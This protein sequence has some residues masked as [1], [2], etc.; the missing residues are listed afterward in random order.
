M[1]FCKFNFMRITVERDGYLLQN[2]FSP[3]LPTLEVA[4]ALGSIVSVSDLLPLSGIPTVQSI[5][6]RQ[7]RAPLLKV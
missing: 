3:D 4:R 1:L 7:K 6:P 5:R 2:N